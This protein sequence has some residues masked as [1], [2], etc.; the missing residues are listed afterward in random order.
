[1]N[2]IKVRE[3]DLK[4]VLETLS[5]ECP[6]EFVTITLN[7]PRI[8]FESTDTKQTKVTILIRDDEHYMSPVKIKEEP[9]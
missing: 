9:L 4:K 1:V 8:T 6:G 5:K 2:N 3:A 7:Y